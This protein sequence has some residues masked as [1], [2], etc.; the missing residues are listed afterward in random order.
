V[1]LDVLLE[2]VEF[3]VDEGWSVRLSPA[4]HT[5]FLD[6][7]GNYNNNWSGVL[8][9]H[10]FSHDSQT[11]TTAEWRRVQQ[12]EEKAE[13]R[14]VLIRNTVQ[15]NVFADPVVTEQRLMSGGAL[16]SPKGSDKYAPCVYY[17]EHPVQPMS[18]M[19][20]RPVFYIENATNLLAQPVTYD[21][22]TQETTVDGTPIT[23]NIDSTD[24]IAISFDYYLTCMLNDISGT[25]IDNTHRVLVPNTQTYS[26][27]SK[28]D[29]RVSLVL[30]EVINPG[31]VAMLHQFSGEIENISAILVELCVEDLV[32]TDADPNP[33]AFPSRTVFDPI[34]WEL[35]DP[36]EPFFTV[37]SGTD[38]VNFGGFSNSG[39][40]GW[41]FA[42]V[43]LFAYYPQEQ[44][45]LDFVDADVKFAWTLDYITG[46]NGTDIRA[47]TQGY[48]GL[49]QGNKVYQFINPFQT[50][51]TAQLENPSFLGPSSV[52][53]PQIIGMAGIPEAPPDVTLNP[54]NFNPTLFNN[55]NNWL[56][57]A[58]F[59]VSRSDATIDA[60]SHPDFSALGD[61]ITFG[62]VFFH[63]RFS[64]L[65]GS[66]GG[67]IYAFEISE[68][69]WDFRGESNSS[70][71]LHCDG[72][73]FAQVV[74]G[75]APPGFINQGNGTY[76][77][78]SGV[79]ANDWMGGSGPFINITFGVLEQQGQAVTVT[80]VP[81]GSSTFTQWLTGDCAGST[82]PVC[83]HV[84]QPTDPQTAQEIIQ[85][86]FDGPIV[87]EGPVT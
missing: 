47:V 63:N 55:T 4:S 56:Q 64:G 52:S 14:P 58:D 10:T 74:P 1:S 70:Q 45:A 51:S 81:D 69:Y 62:I 23:G 71:H 33:Q 36:A 44:G 53:N 2:K 8:A 40:D 35:P 39:G 43:P 31:Q 77:Y 46:P 50:A 57:V 22:F 67:A 82:N 84:L 48:P 79:D 17:G 37:N 32:I 9:R 76:N 49:R 15:P 85:G 29:Y 72:N 41:A 80:A 7:D 75:P 21:S 24:V 5:P 28:E 83:T 30:E 73:L 42:E 34:W 3:P 65:F 38:F 19:V 66:Q 25:S 13:S 18:R 68:F 60:G 54:L 16:I 27:E 59:D 12:I 26:L 6:A 78:S 61:R 11:M 20:I 86:Q 87:E